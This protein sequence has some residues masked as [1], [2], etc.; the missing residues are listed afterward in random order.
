MK[1]DDQHQVPKL[2]YLLGVI[3]AQKR[4]YKEAATHI[5]NYLKQA[6]APADIEEAQKQLAEIT[7]LSAS[8]TRGSD[9]ASGDKK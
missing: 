4:D 5:Q 7:R 1:V 8:A 6:T 9:A 2:E 3:L